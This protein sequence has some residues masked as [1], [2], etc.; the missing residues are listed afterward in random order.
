MDMIV[1]RPNTKPLPP[2]LKLKNQTES[3]L[4]KQKHQE[5]AACLNYSIEVRSW[6]YFTGGGQEK[7]MA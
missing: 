5:R 2:V 1:S 7:I 6:L 4:E 3:G